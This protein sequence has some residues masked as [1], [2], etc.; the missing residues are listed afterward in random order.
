MWLGWLALARGLSRWGHQKAGLGLQAPLRRRPPHGAAGWA[1]VPLPVGHHTGVRPQ[2]ARLTESS[3]G[4][5][6]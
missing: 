5:R 3:L 4:P 6:P 2:E 1:S